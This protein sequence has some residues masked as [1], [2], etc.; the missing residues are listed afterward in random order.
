MPTRAAQNRIDEFMRG[1]TART[2]GARL[3]VLGGGQRPP[4]EPE[5]SAELFALTSRLATEPGQ[6]PPRG[7]AVGGA[8]DGNHSA[9]ES[10][11]MWQTPRL[12]GRPCQ[13]SML[14]LPLR[15]GPVT[16]K[17]M[18]RT[19]KRWAALPPKIS[20]TRPSKE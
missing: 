7:I 11:P 13:I 10:C 9:A 4:M 16:R 15:S 1:L 2:P 5:S 12:S 19:G 17:C 14:R 18:G 8:S 6:E 20:S 3:E